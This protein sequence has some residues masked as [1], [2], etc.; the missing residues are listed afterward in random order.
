M[1]QIR[2]I[3][4]PKHAALVAELQEALGGVSVTDA[5]GFVLERCGSKTLALLNTEIKP[6]PEA[7]A[8]VPVAAPA[9]IASNPVSEAEALLDELIGG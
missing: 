1:T 5:I 2:A 4:K 6:E 3:V 9:P 8:S 7:A